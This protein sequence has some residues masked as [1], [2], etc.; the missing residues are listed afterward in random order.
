[1]S[2][3]K[4]SEQDPGILCCNCKSG[5]LRADTAAICHPSFVDDVVVGIDC[6]KC[7]KL[8]WT[9]QICYKSWTNK[10]TNSRHVNSDKHLRRL[11]EH[12]V[13]S[14]GQD[15]AFSDDHG[16]NV[17]DEISPPEPPTEG[18]GGNNEQTNC[19]LDWITSI[20]HPLGPPALT[21]E[22]IIQNGSFPPNS[23]SPQFYFFE[24][25]NPGQGAKY[26]TAKPFDIPPE[27][28][29]DREA[30]FHLRM[31]KFLTRLTKNE[32]EELAFFMLHVYNAREKNLTIFNKTR[33]PTSTQDF[34][35]FYMGGKKAVAKH[36]PTP[37]VIKTE[38]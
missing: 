6:T 10:Q 36:L 23:S 18:D 27:S 28:V 19:K 20:S 24:S 2:T 34:N 37:V 4:F 25:Q 8:M 31:T 35:D 17:L 13:G 3:L 1:M 15:W 21:L 33:P 26:L 9:C 22:S 12:Q 7:G 11:A 30:E 38:D 29:T 14:E 16:D 32:Q 5:I